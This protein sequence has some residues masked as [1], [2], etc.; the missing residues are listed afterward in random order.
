MPKMK[1]YNEMTIE[2]IRQTEKPE[3]VVSYALQQCMRKDIEQKAVN[4]EQLEFILDADHMSPLEHI[5]QTIL[6]KGI[7]RSLLAQVTRQRTFKFTSS[8]QHYQNYNEYAFIV[9]QTDKDNQIF[10]ESFRQSMDVYQKLLRCGLPKEEARQAL[11]G[12]MEVNLLITADARNMINFFRQRVCMRNVAEMQ[13]FANK[14]LV[15]AHTWFPGLF[16]MVGAGCH[17]TGKCTQGKMQAECCK[18]F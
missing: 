13:I 10:R 5:S 11:P 3:E 4:K 1:T 17:R 6:I 2:V 9:S 12:A 18:P 16:S 15:K 8:S 7:S 14:W